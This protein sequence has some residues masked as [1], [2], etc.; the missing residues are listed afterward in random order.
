MIRILSIVAAAV[1]C[2]YLAFT[3]FFFRE[4]KQQDLCRDIQVV[5]LGSLDKHFINE[6]DLIG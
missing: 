5:V 3:A 4:R 2:A 1:L 6:K